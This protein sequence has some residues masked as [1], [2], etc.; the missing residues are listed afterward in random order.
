MQ[1]FLEVGFILREDIIKI[2]WNTKTTE[3]K[4]ARLA[5]TSEEN[6]I[7][8]PE[9]KKHWTDFYLIAHEHLFVFRKP[10]EGEDIEK[11]RDSMKWW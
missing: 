6:W 1:Q 9:N 8:K 10:A 2:Q 3:K 11:Y 7:D 4:W 5:K